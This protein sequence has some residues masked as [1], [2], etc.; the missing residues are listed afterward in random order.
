M[1]NTSNIAADPGALLLGPRLLQQNAL[2][3]ETRRAVL[4]AVPTSA[5][6]QM[7]RVVAK[8]VPRPAVR[9]WPRPTG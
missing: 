5:R 7:N 2:R 1:Q 6:S 3:T 8:I 9:P 4:G